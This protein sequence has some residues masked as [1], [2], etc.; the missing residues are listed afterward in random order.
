MHVHAMA[1]QVG[2][3]KAAGGGASGSGAPSEADAAAKEEVDS[4]SVFVGNV[5]YNSTP[6]DLQQHFQVLATM[7]RSPCAPCGESPCSGIARPAARPHPMRTRTRASMLP[8]PPSPSARPR[9]STPLSP[10]PPY[11]THPPPRPR[12]S[13]QSCGTVNRVTILT[14]K[15]GNPKAYAYIEFLE[16]DAVNNAVLLDNTELKVGAWE[17]SMIRDTVVR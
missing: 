15:F 1:M 9:H 6:E 10:P 4:R 13:A 17:G 2:D 7:Q 5:D 8:T 12:P 3:G 14:D 11:L 16:V